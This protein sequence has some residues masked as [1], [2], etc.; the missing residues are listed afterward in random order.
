MRVMNKM[1]V[2]NSYF[3]SFCGVGF[4]TTETDREF[5]LKAIVRS[6]RGINQFEYD[7]EE[8]KEEIEQ[9]IF[10]AFYHYGDYTF[11][12]DEPI[13]DVDGEQLP[14]NMPPEKFKIFKKAIEIIEDTFGDIASAN[15]CRSPISMKDFNDILTRKEKFTMNIPL[16]WLGT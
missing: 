8:I 4:Q 14:A 16:I 9:I 7:A 13:M 10:W 2:F 11:R 3:D 6:A 12:K 1:K 15:G 5:Y